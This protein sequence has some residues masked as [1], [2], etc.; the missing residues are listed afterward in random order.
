MKRKILLL[1][2]LISIFSCSKEEA[3]ETENLEAVQLVG[4]APPDCNNNTLTPGLVDEGT[5]YVGNL[6]A[7]SYSVYVT[8]G[9][10]GQVGYARN[11]E[12]YISKKINGTWSIIDVAIVTIPANQH[13]SNNV[14]VLDHTVS[15][16]NW[17]QVTVALGAVTKTDGT[18]LTCYRPRTQNPTVNNCYTSFNFLEWLRFFGDDDYDND[19]LRNNVDSD[20]DDDGIPDSEDTDDDNDGIPDSNDGDDDNDGIPDPDDPN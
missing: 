4:A 3:V 9:F 12:V 5:C 13:L 10:G 20:D 17:G 11:I 19:G 1:T 16:R 6:V 15:D 8:A 18:V 2:L 7:S 14:A